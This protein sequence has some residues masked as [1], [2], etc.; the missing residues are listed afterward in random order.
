[1]Y[2]MYSNPNISLG[3][4]TRYFAEQGIRIGGEEI[5]RSTLSSTM[6]NP[7][8]AQADLEIYEFFKSQGANMVNDVADFSSSNGCYLFQGR[9][10]KES[11]QFNIKDQI[12]VLAPYEGLI[13]SEI[14]L[15]VRKRLMTTPGF[16]GTHKAKNTWLSGKIKCGNCG[17]ALMYSPTQRW[18]NFNHA[19]DSSKTQGTDIE[20]HSGSIRIAY[21][22]CRKRADSKNCIG[23][24][25][26]RVHDVEQVI[27]G[28]MLDKM[29]EF[30][31]LSGGS[32]TKSNPKLTAYNVELLQVEAE[33]E[34]L[35]NTLTGANP[36]LL[37]YANTKIEE[38]DAR[39]QDIIKSIT[40]LN[41]QTISSDRIKRISNHLDNWDNTGFKDRQ[42]VI[43]GLVSRIFATCESVRIEWN[44]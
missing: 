33:I 35:I 15:T 44:I 1:M 34:K 37:S 5:H 11:K 24:G 42:I 39:R 21:F 30:K 16:K 20:N 3:D 23:C 13:P 19:Y 2:E 25:T 7:I 17:S 32:Q 38:L 36:T 10:V 14:W 12:F 40:D 26:L 29:A 43:D 4:I 6:K 41:I 31:T 18:V 22:R 8:Y 28:Q 9:D 27:Y